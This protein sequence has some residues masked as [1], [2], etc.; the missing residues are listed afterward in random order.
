MAKIGTDYG[1]RIVPDG[2]ITS[3]LTIFSFGVGE[4]ISFEEKCAEM[5]AKCVL[6]DPTPRSIEFMR[7]KP[8]EF[9]PYGLSNKCDLVRFYYP[10]DP[11]HV[12]CSIGNLQ[13]TQDYFVGEVIDWDAVL[14]IY[15]MPEL[16]KLDIEGEEYNVIDDMT[17][18]PKYLMV[19]FHGEHKAYID[20]LM[21]IY[22]KMYKNGN[23]YLFI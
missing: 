15:G 22:D 6:F 19:E 14:D 10:K 13:G 23:D 17:F 20:R 9:Y 3:G 8:F 4:D 2:L 21:L 11:T 16:L 18:F 5:G 12:S 1:G 7:G